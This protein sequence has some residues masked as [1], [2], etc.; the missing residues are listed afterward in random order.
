MFLYQFIEIFVANGIS[1]RYLHEH[2]INRN[3]R[4]VLCVY[5]LLIASFSLLCLFSVAISVSWLVFVLCE[6]L[7]QRLNSE[8]LSFYRVCVK[9]ELRCLFPHFAPAKISVQNNKYGK[10]SYQT[11][12]KEMQIFSSRNL[13]NGIQFALFV[14][15]ENSLAYLWTA[16]R[17]TIVRGLVH[18]SDA[19]AAESACLS[20]NSHK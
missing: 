5:S 17:H 15:V 20:F 6:C 9:C 16:Y 7:W 11:N 19:A 10:H 4:L 2:L 13:L 1:S 18:S 3:L 8:N 12:R 14:P